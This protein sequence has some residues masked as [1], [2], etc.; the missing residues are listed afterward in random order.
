MAYSKSVNEKLLIKFKHMLREYNS[1][2]EDAEAVSLS[3]W[4]MNVLTSLLNLRKSDEAIAILKA[5]SGTILLIN[6]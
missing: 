2:Y 4:D 1:P 5:G 3:S 6:K